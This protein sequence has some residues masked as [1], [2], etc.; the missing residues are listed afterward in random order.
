MVS[1]IIRVDRFIRLSAKCVM[2]SRFVPIRIVVI[3]YHG[4]GITGETVKRI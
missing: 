2:N 1:R 3:N 4:K